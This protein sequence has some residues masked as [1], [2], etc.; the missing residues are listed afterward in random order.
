MREIREFKIKL[1]DLKQSLEFKDDTL[2]EKVNNSKSENAKK[3]ESSKL[4]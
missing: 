1:S 3:M 4:K 2:E